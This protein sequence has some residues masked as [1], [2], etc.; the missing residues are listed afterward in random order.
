MQLANKIEENLTQKSTGIN[1][2]PEDHVFVNGIMVGSSSSV[3][4]DYTCFPTPLAFPDYKQ[5]EQRR[6]N[7]PLCHSW[8]GGLLFV[9]GIIRG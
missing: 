5:S 4:F 3:R 7:Q 8:I 1:I 2:T 6:K 9:N